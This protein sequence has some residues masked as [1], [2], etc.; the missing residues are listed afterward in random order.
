MTKEFQRAVLFGLVV[1]WSPEP[2][3]AQW[4]QAV[5]AVFQLIAAC[6]FTVN[7]AIVL[8]RTS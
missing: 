4:A 8:W 6:M 3:E 7:V 1:V 5:D 2:P